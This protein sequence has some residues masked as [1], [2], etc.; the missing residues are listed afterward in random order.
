MKWNAI[1]SVIFIVGY[2][3]YYFIILILLYIRYHDFLILKLKE[4]PNYEEDLGGLWVGNGGKWIGGNFRFRS[5]LPIVD[6]TKDKK[7]QEAINDHN[8]L[9][10][11]F[12]YSALGLIPIII[13]LNI[14]NRL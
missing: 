12:W 5:P 7:I 2:L 11:V 14:I 10:R 8:K 1:L 3:I 6:K 9:I 4:N 13:F